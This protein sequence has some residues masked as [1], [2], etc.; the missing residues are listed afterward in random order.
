MK[1]K[2]TLW[3]PVTVSSVNRGKNIDDKQKVL[4]YKDATRDEVA[5]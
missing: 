5:M 3:F 2:V 1:G 4:N